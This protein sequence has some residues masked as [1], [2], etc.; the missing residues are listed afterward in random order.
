MGLPDVLHKPFEAKQLHQ[1]DFGGLEGESDSLIHE[2]L[3]V[4]KI[5]PIRNFLSDHTCILLGERGTGKSAIF[6]LLANGKLVLGE[7]SSGRAKVVL[8]Q[9]AVEYKS[10]EASIERTVKSPSADDRHR[11]RIVWELLLLHYIR[12]VL[13]EYGDLPTDLADNIEFLKKSFGIP[14]DKPSLLEVVVNSKKRFGVKLDTS[15]ASG[16]PTLEGYVQIGPDGPQPTHEEPL[17][18]LELYSFKQ[19]ANAFFR[20][21]RIRLYLLLDRLDEFVIREEY[22]I[23]KTTLEALL[24]TERSYQEFPN[25]RIKIALR[26]D[27]YRKLDITEF[28]ADKMSSRI[29]KLEWRKDDIREFIAKRILINFLK[30]HAVDNVRVPL[31][32]K[33]YRIDRTGRITL[34]PTD[35]SLR[36]RGTALLNGF[37]NWFRKDKESLSFNDQ[38]NRSIIACFFDAF[39]SHLNGY[40]AKARLE[41]FH[42]LDSHFCLNT[43]QSTPRIMLMFLNE[44]IKVAIDE[45]ELGPPHCTAIAPPI[46][47]TDMFLYAYQNF[48]RNYLEAMAQESKIEPLFRLF[49]NKFGHGRGRCTAAEISTELNILQGRELDE[50]LAI[51]NHL[52]VISCIDK[53]KPAEQ[54]K[55]DL[56]LLFRQPGQV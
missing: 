25:M 28:G 10:F 46:L 41:L 32:G 3:C 36:G 26:A 29:T 2:D 17:A 12:R 45:V 13:E 18:S 53:H 43:K 23:Q 20:D 4:C 9:G 42:Y 49:L 27:L 7:P 56:P 34:E 38:I 24:A 47:K 6:Q 48:K 1:F 21:K 44:C 22:N 14:M 55:Y 31:D 16:L 40:G 54:R 37:L 35:K 19:K 33:V 39:A 15:I 52:G 5:R 30:I 50:F 11:Y 8:I 51:M